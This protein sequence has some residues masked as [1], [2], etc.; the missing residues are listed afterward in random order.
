MWAAQQ[1]TDELVGLKTMGIWIFYLM[2][3]VINFTWKDQPYKC[4]F[5]EITRNVVSLWYKVQSFN[6]ATKCMSYYG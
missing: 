5:Y 6:N 1:E 3:L 2:L 4:C